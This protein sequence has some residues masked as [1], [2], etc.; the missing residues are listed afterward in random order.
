MM[1]RLEALRVGFTAY[2]PRIAA[3]GVPLN[4]QNPRYQPLKKRPRQGGA[5]SWEETH[6]GDA[7]KG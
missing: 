5:K 4:F 3:F 1:S 6:L 7:P 2:R